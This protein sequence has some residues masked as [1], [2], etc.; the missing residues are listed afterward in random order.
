[1]DATAPSCANETSRLNYK[2][3]T[4]VRARELLSHDPK[5]IAVVLHVGYWDGNLKSKVC[6]ILHFFNIT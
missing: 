4:T 3:G 6:I 2:I 5:V 1:M